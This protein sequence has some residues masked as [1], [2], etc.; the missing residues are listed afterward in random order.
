VAKRHIE[1]RAGRSEIYV[2]RDHRL[3]AAYRGPH[4]L[5]EHRVNAGAAVLYLAAD[6]NQCALADYADYMIRYQHQTYNVF[7]AENKIA[8]E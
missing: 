6:A 8:A 1:D 3:A 5:A 2:R 7:G 4:R